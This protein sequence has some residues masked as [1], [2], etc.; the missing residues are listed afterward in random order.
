MNK[1]HRKEG[2]RAPLASTSASVLELLDRSR[3]SSLELWNALSDPEAASWAPAVMELRRTMGYA[4]P[5]AHDDAGRASHFFV[6]CTALLASTAVITRLDAGNSYAGSIMRLPEGRHVLSHSKIVEL[7]ACVKASGWAMDPDRV[8]ELIVALDEGAN[9]R[10]AMLYDLLNV[11]C[12]LEPSPLTA[13]SLLQLF[14]RMMG[15]DTSTKM[16]SLIDDEGM[17]CRTILKSICSSV[18]PG[19]KLGA[20]PLVGALS[21][22]EAIRRLKPFPALNAFMASF[23]YSRTLSSHGYLLAS[24]IPITSVLSSWDTGDDACEQP[25]GTDCV[26]AAG[27]SFDWSLWFEKVVGICEARVDRMATKLFELF[28]KRELMGSLLSRDGSLNDRQREIVLEA[29]LH[30]DAEFTFGRLMET[31]NV[32]YATAYADLSQ[33]KDMGFLQSST[34]GKT[35]VFTAVD[36]LADRLNERLQRTV[37]DAWA[38]IFEPDGSLRSAHRAARDEA[39]RKLKASMPLEDAIL[40]FKSLVYQPDRVSTLLNASLD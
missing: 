28:L 7:G 31:E 36:D 12:N 32:A 39:L 24:F 11:A 40:A 3:D 10:E 18:E 30:E 5:F 4:L 37:P 15:E 29:L 14:A 1:T 33:L 38:E 20:F 16:F 2:D 27:R 35:T 21:A 25:V 6:P 8:F 26:M 34:C 19:G 17:R 23:A 9:P 22:Y 13:E